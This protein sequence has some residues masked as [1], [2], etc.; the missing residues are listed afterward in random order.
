MKKGSTQ[1]YAA[2]ALAAAVT[3]VIVAWRPA[4]AEVVYPVERAKRTFSQKVWTRVT[5]FFRGAAAQAE[6][7]R[8]RREV[9][10]LA[11]LRGDVE[12]LEAENARLR[13]QLGYVEREPGAWIAAGVLSTGGAACAG[14]RIRVNKGTIAGVA[15]GAVVAV[16]DG[17]VGR[18]VAVSPH[19]CEV[20]LLTDASVKVACEVESASG[21]ALSGILC[22]GDGDM[23]LLRHV[24]GSGEPPPRARVLTS[25]RGGVFPRGFEVGFFIGVREDGSGLSRIGDVQPAV[26]YSA[27]DDVFIRRGK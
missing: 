1:S 4:A 7:V 22:G 21:R 10:S 24:I 13:R 27:L 26:D 18:V 23:L 2:I 15:V 25:G 6:N 3:A 20:A 16:P 8:L 17:L 12:R 9:E 19:T 14:D 5:G 11:V